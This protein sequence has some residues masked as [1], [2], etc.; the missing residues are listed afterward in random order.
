MFHNRLTASLNEIDSHLSAAPKQTVELI[1]NHLIDTI[2]R[3]GGSRWLTFNTIVFNCG[4]VA[5]NGGVR[6]SN[7][8]LADPPQ[9]SSV[10]VISLQDSLCRWNIQSVLAYPDNASSRAFSTIQAKLSTPFF[11]L[12]KWGADFLNSCEPSAEH[13]M[14]ISDLSC[15]CLSQ[16]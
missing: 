11:C 3:H 14:N 5:V 8:C 12:W 4:S 9:G 16:S 13:H 6:S 7:S 10:W 15:L 1:F 2:I